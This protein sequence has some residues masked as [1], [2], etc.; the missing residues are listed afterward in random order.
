[1]GAAMGYLLDTCILSELIR[2]HP[3]P[4]ALEVMQ[5]LPRDEL[6]ISVITLGELR[7]GI[8]Q[9]PASAR[10]RQL[11][12]WFEDHIRPLY[13]D[14]TLI[15]DADIALRWG[16]LRANLQQEG[17]TM[18]TPD[19]LIAATALTH[20]LVVVTRNENDFTRTGVSILNPWN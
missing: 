3:S 20:D 1:M 9:M 19:S 14:H 2:K 17:Y 5:A 7:R 12:A 16:I 6:F 13:R 15:V 10:K 8:E 18:Q 4:H 11:T